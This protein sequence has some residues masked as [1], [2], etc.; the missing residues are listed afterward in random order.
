M[1]TLENLDCLLRIPIDNS[2][3]FQQ[4]SGTIVT[5][6]DQEGISDSL[7]PQFLKILDFIKRSAY[8]YNEDWEKEYQGYYSKVHF[9]PD[10]DLGFKL[11]KLKWVSRM[12]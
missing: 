10:T 1:C 5:N 6:Y 12:K 4:C 2:S 8:Y 11:Y 7:K 9:I 3:C